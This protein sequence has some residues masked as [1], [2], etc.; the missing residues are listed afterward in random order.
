[1]GLNG[2]RTSSI[3]TAVCLTLSAPLSVSALETGH[4]GSYQ[5]GKSLPQ[6]HR[7]HPPGEAAQPS[8]RESTHADAKGENDP[9][10][11]QRL[12]YLFGPVRSRTQTQQCWN[13]IS[14]FQ[15]LRFIVCRRK[16][17]LKEQFLLQKQEGDL[18]TAWPLPK[19]LLELF[20]LIVNDQRHIQI[21]VLFACKI[22]IKPKYSLS[23][24]F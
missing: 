6:R 2:I 3:M 9:D 4:V 21:F 18:R 20:R 13:V 5:R 11:A 8:R 24:I 19:L 22:F 10:G 12:L 1:M 7:L 17:C 14:R 23:V 16:E 15:G